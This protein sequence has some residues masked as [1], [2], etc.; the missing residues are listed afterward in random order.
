MKS[1]NR[2]G[3]ALDELSE[4]EAFITGSDVYRMVEASRPSKVTLDN[5]TVG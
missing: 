1:G 5:F 3:R 4:F 2:W